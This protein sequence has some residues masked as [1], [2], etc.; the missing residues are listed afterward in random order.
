V[1]EARVVDPQGL[2]LTA[3]QQETPVGSGGG[4]GVKAGEV[5]AGAAGTG[6]VAEKAVATGTAMVTTGIRRTRLT[7]G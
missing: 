4:S 1:V 3:L 2:E 6:M 5:A 7:G